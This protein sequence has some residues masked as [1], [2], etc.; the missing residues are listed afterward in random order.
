MME[1][2][3]ELEFPPIFDI[4]PPPPPP[5]MEEDEYECG[6]CQQQ[7]EMVSSYI[8]DTFYNIIIIIVFIISML[9]ILFTLSMF[10]W[11]KLN[12]QKRKR[13]ESTIIS[14][15]QIENIPKLSYN[16]IPN[17][18]LLSHQNYYTNMP[19]II[20]P[21]FQSNAIQGDYETVDSLY[22]SDTSFSISS[23]STISQSRTSNND[24]RSKTSGS[25]ASSRISGF[26]Y[27]HWRGERFGENSQERRPPS[28]QEEIQ[29]DRKSESINQNLEEHKLDRSQGS[30]SPY[31]EE[32]HHQEMRQ[33]SISFPQEHPQHR[34][35]G[36]I[37]DINKEMHEERKQ[38]S[39]FH[40]NQD[41]PVTE[42]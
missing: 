25:S 5:W 23:S 17:Q 42:L 37:Q 39:I 33:G 34:S 27:Q 16:F 35:Q 15:Y 12:Q 30:I 10:L 7:Q 20:I 14:E 26:N 2:E 18:Q 24:A 6:S 22:Y 29:C 40:Q 36:S 3:W 9:I 11:R 19:S 21:A 38:E 1:E 31:A 32:E 41:E 13:T 4:P 28:I 8:G